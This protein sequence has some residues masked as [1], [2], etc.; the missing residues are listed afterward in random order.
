MTQS[1]GEQITQA[2]NQLWKS[3][4]G[5]LTSLDTAHLAGYA[6][7]ILGFFD[8]IALMIPPQFLNPTWEFSL[9]GQLIE[10]VPVPL[11]G[12]ALIFAGGRDDRKGW[13]L[14]AL[15]AI[16]WLTLGVGILY[17][18]MIPWA[19]VNTFRIYRQNNEQINQ[20][21]IQGVEQIA[22]VRSNLDSVQTEEDLAK[23]IGQVSNQVVAPTDLSAPVASLKETLATSLAQG[24][25]DLKSQAEATRSQQRIELFKNSGKWN[26]GA[27]VSGTILI[28]IWKSTPWARS[29]S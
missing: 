19:S 6:L 22:Q 13:E 17:F 20:Q 28:L 29:A 18:L 4:T 15:K 5:L 2:I 9:F 10:R 26:L 21:L 8:W 7:L 12:L 11:I 25:S 27:L 3:R 23:L 14:P 16:S 1:S 24:E